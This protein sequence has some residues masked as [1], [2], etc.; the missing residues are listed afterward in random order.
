VDYLQGVLILSAPLGSTTSDGGLVSDGSAAFDQ[1]LV[2]QYEYTPPA[3][4]SDAMAIGGRVEAWATGRLRFGATL[5]DESQDVDELRM[6]GVDLR[7]QL[8]AQSYAE[9]EFAQS[10]GT[11]LAR[12]TSTD[13]GLTIIGSGGTT[14]DATALRF[15]SRFDFGDLGLAMPGFVGLYA[16]Q[17]EAGF[18]TLYE[19]IT[20][21]QTLL[22]IQGEIAITERLSFYAMAEQFDSDSGEEKTSAEINVLYDINDTW[23]IGL[24]IETLDQSVPGDAT[25]TGSRTD[26][27]LRLTYRGFEDTEVYVFGQ[28][29]LDVSGGLSDNDRLG[30]GFSTALSERLSASGEV[31][32]GDTGQAGAFRLTYAP[33]SEKSYYLGY[34]LD[35]IDPDTGVAPVAE[36]GTIVAGARTQNSSNLSSFIETKSDLPAPVQSITNAFGVTYT[37]SAQ[38]AIGG[39]I[40]TGTVRDEVN[41]DFDRD[42]VSVG[43]TFAE[44]DLRTANLRL[45]YR[46]EDG[47][48]VAQ[49]RD[50]WGLV[51]GYSTKVNENWRFIAGLDALY[52]DSAEDDF[53]NGEYTRLRLGYAY[54]PIEN[55]RLNLL[56]SYEYLNDLP[57][58]DQI[59]ANGNVDGPQQRSHVLSVNGSYDL[60]QRLT[61]G[62]KLGYRSSEIADRGT[63]VFTS[64]TA[65]LGVARLDWHAVHEWDVLAEGRVLLSEE[66]G[67]DETSA[68]LG[69]YRHVGEN[70]KIGVGYQWGAVS[71]DLTDLDYTSQGLF[72]NLIAKF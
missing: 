12:S 59:D 70:A 42:A 56:F 38:W 35:A 71:D 10:E 20:D 31:S 48:G 6:T 52:S 4:I 41:G 58:E 11:G 46:T 54:R 67:T 28:S 50:T 33:S 65:T 18:A 72:V 16:E 29:T 62:G 17:K 3:G 36:N 2:V 15:D 63:D 14:A 25:R 5:I 23:A 27:A 19:D 34:D 21:D 39:S 44:E 9:I 57:G 8:S 60:T 53:R 68:L 51:G 26:A 66:T 49:D 37:P 30:A 1:N 22:G 55:E 43:F 45:E 69:V 24:G 61:F 7:Y 13:G 47:D 64:D 32:D 40:E